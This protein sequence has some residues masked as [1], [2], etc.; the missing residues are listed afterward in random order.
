M[1]MLKVFNMVMVDKPI[2]VPEY[3][4]PQIEDAPE[5]FKAYWWQILLLFDKMHDALD[6]EAKEVCRDRMPL[7]ELRS[8]LPGKVPCYKFFVPDGWLVFPEEASA[9]A[10]AMKSDLGG[11]H[12]FFDQWAAYN[13]LSANHSGHRVR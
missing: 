3:Y 11:E 9:I 6:W 8:N 1:N 5:F 13:K 12:L 10:T 2:I 7:L 4:K